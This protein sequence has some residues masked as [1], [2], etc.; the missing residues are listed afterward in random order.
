MAKGHGIRGDALAFATLPATRWHRAASC[1]PAQ[2]GLQ[3]RERGAAGLLRGDQPCDCCRHRDNER[4]L[5]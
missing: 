5:G 3:I 4:Y 2:V 1:Q